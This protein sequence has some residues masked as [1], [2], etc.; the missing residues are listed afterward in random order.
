[1]KWKKF[2]IQTSTQALDYLGELFDEIG[3]EGM[4]IEDKIPLSQEELSQMFVDIPADPGPDDGKAQVSFY[5]DNTYDVPATL[6]ALQEKLQELKQYVQDSGTLEIQE[7]ETE[8]KDWMNNWKAFFKPFMVED[9]L[10]KPTWEAVPADM[11]GKYILE[12]DPGIA[13]GTGQHETTQLCLKGL[14]AFMEP[15]D[16][17][18]DVGCGSGILSIGALLLGA[19]KAVGTDLDPAAITASQE[20]REANALPA[21]R[22]QVYIGNL[23]NDEVLKAQV[24]FDCYDIVVANIL[25]DVIIPLQEVIAPH[26]KMGGIFISSGIIDSKE[27]EVA[28]AI[29]KNPALEIVEIKHLKDWVSIVA[30]RVK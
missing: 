18:L 20:N 25:A 29:S 16:L 17:V 15:G 6:L 4:E 23:I 24:G 2:T 26:L 28:A 22:F 9:I 1:M 30:R 21:E 8:D 3:I 10:I 14:K 7:S 19:A 11:Q 27:Q 5:L 12:I 13:F